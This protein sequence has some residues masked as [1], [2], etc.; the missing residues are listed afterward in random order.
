[1]G[2]NPSILARCIQ[3]YRRS[4]GG[5][6]DIVDA[7]RSRTRTRRGRRVT[8]RTLGTIPVYRGKRCKDAKIIA[9]HK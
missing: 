2:R 6:L 1:M 7:L 5:T 9:T 3:L 4:I 8:I